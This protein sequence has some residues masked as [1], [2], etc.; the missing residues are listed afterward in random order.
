MGRILDFLEN[1]FGALSSFS[2]MKW[3]DIAEILLIAVFVYQ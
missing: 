1:Y 3:I 2:T